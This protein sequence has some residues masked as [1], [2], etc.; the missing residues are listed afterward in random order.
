[1]IYREATREDLE[2]VWDKDIREN[3]NDDRWG[4]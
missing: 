2:N 3:P 1:M 4:R